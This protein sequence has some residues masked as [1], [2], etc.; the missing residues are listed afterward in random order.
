LPLALAT[1]GA[2]KPGF[3]DLAVVCHRLAQAN[4]TSPIAVATQLA[5]LLAELP[6][7][8]GAESVGPFC[9]LRL[10]LAPLAAHL[11]R[12]AQDHCL[13]RGQEGVDQR[14][15]IEFSSPNAARKLGFHHLRGTALGAAL[16]RLYA[17]R[18]YD[19]VRVNYLGDF[20]HNIGLL[21]WKLDQVAETEALTPRRLQEL[22][23]AANQDQ[24]RDPDT[25][26]AGAR[27]W[28]RRLEAA[29]PA[30]SAR[31]QL[32]TQATRQALEEAYARLG[33][34]FDDW[35]GES[36]YAEA[37]RAIPTRLLQAGVA[38]QGEAGVVFVPGADGR[39]PIVLLTRDG[40]TTYESRDIAAL[41]E[42]YQDYSYDRSL[43]LTDIG[44]GTRFEAL[45]EAAAAAGDA[46]AGG[47]QHL[48]FGQMRLGGA[49][50]KSREG[51]TL[52]L[53]EVLDEAVTLA[54]AVLGERGSDPD[55][56]LAETVGVG[57]VVFS[58]LRMRRS[59]D[60][61]F[62]LAQAVSLQ[63]ATAPRVQYTHAR[64]LA[65]LRKSGGDTAQALASADWS[66]LTA[67]EERTVVLAIGALEEAAATAVSHDDVSYIADALL[68]IADA[69]G[70]Y[71][72]AGKHDSA[73]RVLSDDARL[74]SARLGLAA[75]VATATAEGL[76]LL[77]IGAPDQM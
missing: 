52:E 53:D 67:P 21:L 15:V 77:G 69:W 36:V 40:Q 23:V 56:A 35:R 9:N 18:G 39:Q 71:Q 6:E 75:L 14:L 22:Y 42:R 32:V 63:G 46:G 30:A 43:Y 5:P 13:L 57:A 12:R 27:A 74:R 54:A 51:T 64:A 70:T 8:A 38:E 65:I 55:P 49:K 60:F 41:S 16:A 37:A 7:V 1:V 45:I 72:T 31:W 17:A 24:A 62:D 66:G 2:A 20:G 26:K 10:E 25:V 50:A 4:G 29:D 34:V 28:L 19:V 11:S 73:L 68:E 47:A 33:V 48:G 59:A 61:D 76:A 58:Q 44:Q 3:G